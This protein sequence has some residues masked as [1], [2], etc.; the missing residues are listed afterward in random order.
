M[1]TPYKRRYKSY[2]TR[3]E[4]AQLFEVAPNT[5]NRWVRGGK[6]PSVVSPGGRRRYPV[7]AILKL[8]PVP[9]R[10]VQT[11]LMEAGHEKTR[12]RRNT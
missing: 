3:S 5:V 2:F 11:P 9:M 12:R 8:L 4:I 6:L 1:Q 10:D 7:D